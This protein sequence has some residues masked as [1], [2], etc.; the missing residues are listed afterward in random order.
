[1]NKYGLPTKIFLLSNHFAIVFVKPISSNHFVNTEKKITNK[2]ISLPNPCPATSLAVP[3]PANTKNSKDSRLGQTKS[4]KTQPQ[5]QP[6]N[7][8]PIRTPYSVIIAP[9]GINQPLNISNTMISE[10]IQN[11]VPDFA[12][13]LIDLHS[14]DIFEC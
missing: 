13:P 10:C 14:L 11:A 5:T 12:F 1:M 6:K 9:S 8:I 7:I 3:I 4:T 2:I